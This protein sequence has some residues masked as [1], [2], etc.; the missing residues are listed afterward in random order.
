MKKQKIIAVAALVALLATGCSKD[1]AG[2]YRLFAERMVSAGSGA[3]VMIDPG[4][5]SA[6]WISGET[7]NI[8]NHVYTIGGNATDGYSVN[9]GDDVLGSTFYA[10]YP[11]SS[12]GG[13][14]VTVTHT[15]SGSGNTVEINRLVLNF[16]NDGTHD[17]V[18]PMSTAGITAES[19]TIT[20]N[21]LT[22]GLK[23]T[24]S[25]A[26]AERD[27]TLGSLRIVTYG[28]DAT[29]SPIAAYNGVTAR[30]AVQGP[31]VPGGMVGETEGD[32]SVLYAS[33][34]YF[35]LSTE[36][37]PGK[38]IPH[39]GNIS[40]CIPITVSSVKTLQV[41]GYSPDGTQLFSRTKNLDNAITI[42]RN[43]MYVIPEIEI[44]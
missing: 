34:M 35:T 39:N 31:A 27:Y 26:S 37:N 38:A 28:D 43:I 9:T 24:L 17:V 32:V 12:F 5:L 2:H 23:L 36:G 25:D 29:A 6:Q 16:H 14:D 13:N 15:G 3:K 21:H 11:G 1:H 10:I 19:S 40:L 4:D 8:N 41:T 33:Q 42:S 30:W 22:G 7:I 20:F 18:F 44:D